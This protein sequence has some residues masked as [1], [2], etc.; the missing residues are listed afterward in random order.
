[1]DCLSIRA[2]SN[3][4]ITAEQNQGKE[5]VSARVAGCD[6]QH[7]RSRGGVGWEQD[8][9][10][11]SARKHMVSVVYVVGTSACEAESEGS[12][13]FGHPFLPTWLD[14]ERRRSCK[15]DHAGANP[16]VGSQH[17]NRPDGVTDSTRLS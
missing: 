11:P 9:P 15:P 16:V 12:T 8:P 5:A 14:T 10:A 2:G 4:V 6:A 3:P 13:P 7:L 1:M 17:N